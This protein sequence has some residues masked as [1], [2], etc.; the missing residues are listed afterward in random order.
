[1]KNKKKRIIGLITVTLISLVLVFLI[2]KVLVSKKQASSSS[3][4]EDLFAKENA[5]LVCPIN[6]NLCLT[7]IP[8]SMDGTN[9]F[10]V[11]VLSDIEEEKEFQTTDTFRARDT[12]LVVWDDYSERFWVYSGDV[13]TFYWDYQDGVWIKHTYNADLSIEVPVALKNARPNY[14]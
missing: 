6:N 5:R 9:G 8:V 13:G 12:L 3:V 11:K 2:H 14:F 7:L 1:M 4:S 10:S